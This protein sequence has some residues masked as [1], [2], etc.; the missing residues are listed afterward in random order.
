MRILVLMGGPSSEHAISLKSGQGVL[1]ALRRKGW[2]AEALILPKDLPVEDTAT[3]CRQAIADRQ[4]DA[5]FIALHGPFG[6]DGTVQALCEHLRVPYTGSDAMASR[7]GMNKVAARMKFTE[8]GLLVPRGAVVNAADATAIAQAAQD[9]G[10][11]LVVK[12]PH[13]GSSIGVSIVRRAGELPPAIGEAAK[14]ESP[15]LL[16]QFIAGR[17]LTV[18]VFDERAL[19]VIE[20]K[21]KQA[22]FDFTAKYTPG[23]TDYIVPAQL[24]EETTRIAQTIGLRAH[25]AV[26]CRHFSR[27]DLMLSDDGRMFVL[28][29][30]TIPGFTPTSLVP[31]A[32]ACAGISYDDV[33]DRLVKAAMASAPARAPLVRA[34]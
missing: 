22:F 20:V 32:A 11:P 28:E 30:N 12:P 27:T 5:V 21:P 3:L 26:G 4:L 33:C 29:I 9:I 1:D 2:D 6:E 25:Q 16:E 13:Q 8:A 24:D 23:Q 31:K 15:V 17:E 10:L 7:T 34:H 14:Y 18:G 19:P